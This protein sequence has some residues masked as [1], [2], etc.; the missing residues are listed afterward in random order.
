MKVDLHK[1]SSDFS[2]CIPSLITRFKPRIRTLCYS[3]VSTSVHTRGGI[4][5]TLNVP[6]IFLISL[7]CSFHR[8]TMNNHIEISVLSESSSR[9]SSYRNSHIKIFVLLVE[10]VIYPYIIFTFDIN[11]YLHLQVY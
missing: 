11:K 9:N 2:L 6:S 10:L 4:P 7:R 1:D 8:H 5:Q 3:W